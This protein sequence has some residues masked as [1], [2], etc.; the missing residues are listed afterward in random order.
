[1]TGFALITIPLAVYALWLFNRAGWQAIRWAAFGG[2]VGIVLAVCAVRAMGDDNGNE[3]VRPV[4]MPTTVMDTDLARVDEVD[5]I[6]VETLL[7]PAGRVY[8][9]EVSFWTDGVLRDRWWS[10]DE[11]EHISG[12]WRWQYDR[13]QYGECGVMV[14]C[15]AEIRAKACRWEWTVIDTNVQDASIVGLEK[16]PLSRCD[17]WLHDHDC[18]PLGDGK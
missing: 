17:F 8:R 18:V 16:P 2:L 9:K 4:V 7:T 12:F 11:P 5:E 1:M 14:N 15:L 13:W 6:L 10:D 3:P